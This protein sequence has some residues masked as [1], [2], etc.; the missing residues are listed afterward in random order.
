M[1][2]NL[3]GEL[4]MTKEIVNITHNGVD[5]ISPELNEVLNSIVEKIK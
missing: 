2:L 3:L 1:N 5:N 4:P